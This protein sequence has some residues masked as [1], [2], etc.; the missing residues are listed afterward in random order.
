MDL[1]H[2]VTKAEPFW[3]NCRECGAELLGDT[4][5]QRLGLCKEHRASSVRELIVKLE[6]EDADID[7]PRVS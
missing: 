6:H 1:L 7:R 5:G 3:Y 2:I 4:R